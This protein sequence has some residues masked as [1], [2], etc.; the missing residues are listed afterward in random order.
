MDRWILRTHKSRT[1]RG[2]DRRTDRQMDRGTKE[3]KC[4][5]I[6]GYKGHT[7]RYREVII[8]RCIDRQ[9]DRYT[10]K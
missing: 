4:R 1:D 9:K 10:E 2:T 8:D 5:K 6:N 7:V 3:L